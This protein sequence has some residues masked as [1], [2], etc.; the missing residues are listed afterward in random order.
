MIRSNMADV[1]SSLVPSG[2]LTNGL[3]QTVKCS[4]DRV[5]CTPTEKLEASEKMDGSRRADSS[6]NL[7]LKIHSFQYSILLEEHF[8]QSIRLEIVSLKNMVSRQGG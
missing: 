4:E 1:Q 7:D 6:K 8:N 5:L 2:S 3:E